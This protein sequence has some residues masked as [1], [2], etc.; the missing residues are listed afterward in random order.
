MAKTNNVLWTGGWDSTFRVI[1]LYRLGATIQPIYVIDHNR[2]SSSKELEA[3]ENISSRIDLKFKHSKGQ[4][5]PL[6]IIKRQDI[7]SNLSLKVIHKFLR[8][9]VNLGK[10]YYWLA[11]IAKKYE[12]KD[13]E[14][15]LHNEDLDKF[16]LFDQLI[17]FK[18]E[19][20]GS[21][22]RLNTKKI[23]FSRKYLFSNMTFP[24]VTISKPEMKTIAEENNFAD[25]MELT[26]FCH[27]SNEKPCGKCAPCKQYVRDGFGYL[28]K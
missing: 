6:K 17:E 15:S 8:Y 2:I 20:I 24:L 23:G 27:K 12:Y 25:L 3:I 28:L 19:K 13:L 16:F 22:W 21:N 5:L 9:K 14:L 18:D 10:Q 4:I 7:P 1:Q 26:W 11:C